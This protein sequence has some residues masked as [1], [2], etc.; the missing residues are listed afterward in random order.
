MDV[1]FHRSHASPVPTSPMRLPLNPQG[2]NAAILQRIASASAE[3]Q[4]ILCNQS[5]PGSQ[6]RDQVTRTPGGWGLR[7]SQTPAALRRF[8]RRKRHPAC[9]IHSAGSKKNGPSHTHPGWA[10]LLYT[11]MF[12][13][14]Q[15]SI[16]RLVSNTSRYLLLSAK[17]ARASSSLP[18]SSVGT[19]AHSASVSGD[20][21]L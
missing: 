2:T 8:R 17:A 11:G 1:R 12:S 5:R 9:S 4:A 19:A 6:P 13:S 20:T 3:I 14:S 18:V 15:E 16:R 7:L 10:I 21:A